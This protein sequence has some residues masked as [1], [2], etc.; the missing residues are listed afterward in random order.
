MRPVRPKHAV[1]IA[2]PPHSAEELSRPHDHAACG[3]QH[4]FDQNRGSAFA[5]FSKT[6]L[7]I[8]E[9]VDSARCAFQT[10]RAAIAIRRVRSRHRKQQ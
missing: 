7:K 3:L 4:R 10:E 2:E 8:A 9:T 1:A 5:M 6:L